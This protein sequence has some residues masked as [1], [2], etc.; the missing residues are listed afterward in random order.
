M[1]FTKKIVTGLLVAALT[2]SGVSV[3]GA[4]VKAAEAQGTETTAE[5]IKYVPSTMADYWSAEEKNAPEMENYVFAGWYQKDGEKFAALKEADIT[6]PAADAYAKFVPAQVLSI[7]A[8]ID[9]KTSKEGA[10]RDT[11]ASIRLVSGVD[12]TNYQKVGF[13]VLLAN[14]K[15][16]GTLETTKLYNGLKVSAEATKTYEANQL[17]GS[18]AKY[19]S[20]WRLDEIVSANDGKIIN[21]TPYWITMDGTKVEGLTKYVHIE[22]GYLGYISIPIN[23]RNAEKIAAGTLSLKYPAGL[24]LVAEKTEFDGVFPAG[25]MKF[26]D[27]GNNTINFVGN[28]STVKTDVPARG[29]YAN[30]RFTAGESGYAGAGTGFLDFQI[31]KEAFCDWEENPIEIHAWDICY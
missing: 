27:A 23:L 21:V 15:D 7:K 8:Q 12:S 25:E 28:A 22:D 6:A 30:L 9:A 29:I 1:R 19:F 13:R 10:L 26:Y 24:E 5:G 18:A 2:V 17:F 3:M 16:L 20:A 14:Q 11:A 4:G 31:E